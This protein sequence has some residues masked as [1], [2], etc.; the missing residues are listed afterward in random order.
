M[1]KTQADLV[2]ECLRA[3]HGCPVDVW[4]LASRS[5]SAAPH[6]VIIALRRR[7][8]DIRNEMRHSKGKKI[9]STYRL[10]S[11]QPPPEKERPAREAGPSKPQD[12]EPQ[13]SL[14]LEIPSTPWPD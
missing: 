1:K 10:V 3:A 12:P 8:F 2:L 7:G 5:G 14:A 6:N 13:A 9:W 11:S 4:T